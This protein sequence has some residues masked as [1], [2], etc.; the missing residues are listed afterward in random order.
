MHRMVCLKRVDWTRLVQKQGLV[1]TVDTDPSDPF[2]HYWREGSY[3]SFDLEEIEALEKAAKVVFEMCIEAGDY[4]AEHPE[5]M[6][7]M[8][9]PEW[10][11]AMVLHEWNRDP[12]FGS[13]YGRFDFRF[14]GFNYPAPEMRVPKLYEFNADTP[15]GLVESTAIQWAWLENLAVGEDQW[16]HAYE[17]L[18]LAWKRNMELIVRDRGLSSPTVHFAIGDGQG[19]FEDEM[20]CLQIASAC[21]DAGYG[22]KTIFME[23][24]K[25]GDDGRFY[26]EEDQHIDVIF[27]LYP[28]EHMVHQEFGRAAFEDMERPNGT[29]WIESPYKMLWSNKALLA[30]LW[31]L[32]K[33]DAEKAQYLL[34]AYFEEDAPDMPVG[35]A[36]K[37]LLSREGANISL[38]APDGTELVEVIDKE[39]GEEGFILQELAQPPIFTSDEY[40]IVHPVLGIW[41][42][43]GEP[44]GMLIRESASPVTDDFANFVPHIITSKDGQR[45]YTHKPVPLY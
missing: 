4:M 37:P 38:V 13:V 7:R 35:Y 40:G 29:Y 28:W 14:G 21:K 24:I 30:V 18:V 17:M 43:D 27:K 1:Y 8:G 5:L 25:L 12:E 41:M 16:N 31:M 45:A 39:Y 10:A 9:I 36:R 42:I 2:H 3:Y 15:T 32:F 26:D 34:P 11:H 19:S 44:A 20:N 33:D 23:N 22:I 6:I